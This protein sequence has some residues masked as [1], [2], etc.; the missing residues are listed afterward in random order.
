M[1]EALVPDDAD[2]ATRLLD[3]SHGKANRLVARLWRWH[4]VNKEFLARQSRSAQCL[5]E[6]RGFYNLTVQKIST[7]LRY[8][9]LH[10]DG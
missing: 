10:N 5:R 7:R 4:Y 6:S 3:S 1:L 9:K 2:G 8:L